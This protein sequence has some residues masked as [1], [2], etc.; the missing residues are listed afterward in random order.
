M[1]TALSDPDDPPTQESIGETLG[2]AAG[3]WS[4]FTQTLADNDVVAEWRHFRDGGW[5]LKATRGRKTVAWADIHDGFFRV[6]FHFAE[7]LRPALLSNETLSRDLRRRIADTPPRGKLVSI[8]LDVQDVDDLPNVA[9][10]LSAR[11]SLR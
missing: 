3:A 8:A 9:S 1:G 2:P 6:A 5:L 7:R 4:A 11:L 10:V